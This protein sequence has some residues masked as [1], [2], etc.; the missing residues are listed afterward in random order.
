MMPFK[1]YKYIGP[2]PNILEDSGESYWFRK[3]MLKPVRHLLQ[4]RVLLVNIQ[5]CKFL[6]RIHHIGK[7]TVIFLQFHYPESMIRGTPASTKMPVKKKGYIAQKLYSIL[8][9]IVTVKYGSY[10]FSA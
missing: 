3:R 10:I 9:V 6:K 4:Y 8:V 1:R 2:E 5:F 7:Q